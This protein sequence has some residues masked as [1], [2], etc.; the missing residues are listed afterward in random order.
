MA[1][2]C[3]Y[4]FA[5][6]ILA[7]VLQNYEVIPVKTKLIFFIVVM[8]VCGNALSI[9]LYKRA[10]RSWTGTWRYT[11]L[12]NTILISATS[13]L[14][15]SAGAAG[16]ER[17]GAVRKAS[18]GV[19][20]LSLLG[21]VGGA[22]AAIYRPV[23]NLSCRVPESDLKKISD[24]SEGILPE[25]DEAGTNLWLDVIREALLH[26]A[27]VFHKQ[28]LS[29][30][31][32][33]DASSQSSVTKS[34]PFIVPGINEHLF[35]I[36]FSDESDS[37]VDLTQFQ[38]TEILPDSIYI[39]RN[40]EDKWLIISSDHNGDISFCHLSEEKEWVSDSQSSHITSV[41]ENE[42]PDCKIDQK[43][44]SMIKSASRQVFN[45]RMDTFIIFQDFL[46]AGLPLRLSMASAFYPLKAVA[47]PS[48]IRFQ[49]AGIS[50]YPANL[51]A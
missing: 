18:Y 24:L 20:G 28:H 17:G 44:Q 33:A 48:L 39:H 41:S 46:I 6:N 51:S 25:F 49:K 4:N 34:L 9:T 42:K 38:A 13:V 23:S 22:P 50:Q 47:Y 26:N 7:V 12:D 5:S 3:I 11:L 43:R 15:G 1:V 2:W 21:L 8:L 30:N 35:R 31:E 27:V 45:Y 16:G 14:L 40:N 10:P 32:N 37:I 19:I 36:I 29:Q